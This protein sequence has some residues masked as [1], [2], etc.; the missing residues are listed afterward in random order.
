MNRLELSSK[1]G[2]LARQSP[3]FA[4]RNPTLGPD[5]RA[6]P[7]S[8]DVVRL[9][10]GDDS[11]PPPRSTWAAPAR[12][13]G[14]GPSASTYQSA[15]HSSTLPLMSCAPKTLAPDG[16]L[17]TRTGRGAQLLPDC[18]LTRVTAVAHEVVLPHG[19]VVGFVP[20]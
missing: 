5:S 18:S 11:H 17:P 8:L 9:W 15:V 7:Q 16:W 2:K 1:G 10:E 3:S 6:E 4:Q 20:R 14:P 19:N 13:A 12:G